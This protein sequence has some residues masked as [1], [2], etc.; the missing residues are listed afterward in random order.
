MY[1]YHVMLLFIFYL[2]ENYLHNMTNHKEVN[3]VVETRGNY[4]FS[5]V[6]IKTFNSFF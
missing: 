6:Q 5:L 1:A 2:L 3:I 4:Y